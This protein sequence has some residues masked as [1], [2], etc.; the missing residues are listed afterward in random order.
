MI[1]VY[2]QVGIVV[3]DV[4]LVKGVVNVGFMAER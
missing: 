3:V 1:A 2:V 4:W